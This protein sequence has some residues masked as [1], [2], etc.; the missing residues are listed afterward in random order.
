MTDSTCVC[1]NRNIKLASQCQ[2]QQHRCN[3]E[4]YESSC[5]A[6]CHDCICS[7]DVERCLFV[8]VGDEDHYCNCYYVITKRWSP[9]KARKHDCNC[10]SVVRHKYGS[11][12]ATSHTCVCR[13][14]PKQCKS[15]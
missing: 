5:K 15:T 9:C 6:G 14:A 13:F 10:F 3:C 8:S 1:L 2:A 7:S 12:L 4:K 11:C